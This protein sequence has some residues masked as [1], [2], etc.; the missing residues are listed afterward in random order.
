MNKLIPRAITPKITQLCSIFPVVTIT[1]PRQSGK[2]TLC[3]EAFPQFSYFN[4]ECA[5]TRKIIERGVQTWLET[6]SANGKGII[7]D[8]AQRIPELFSAV[9]IV[10]DEN[11]ERKFILSG[12]NNFLLMEKITQSLAGRAA[13]LKL[14]PF[15]LAELGKERTAGSLETLVLRGGFPRV[16]NALATVD[17]GETVAPETLLADIFGNYNDTYVERDVRQIEE[18]RNLSAFRNFMKL[19][20][21]SVG[22]EFNAQSF[23]TAL[24]VSVPTIQSWLSILEASYII[25]RL[26]PFFKNIKKR[27]SKRSKIYFCD[28][29]LACWL[30][31]IENEKQL[32]THP[33]RGRLF[34]NL[35]VLEFFKRRY[36]AGENAS[37]LYFYRDSSQREVDIVEERAS[38]FYAYEIKTASEIHD[39]FFRTLDY[40]RKILGDEVAS[41]KVI[42]DGHAELTIPENGIINFRNL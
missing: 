31:D 35:V 28:T 37:R 9:Q 23:A 13:I 12:S 15:S 26:P 8:E 29:G 39:D 1:G 16:W 4:L 10:S 7:I 14:L 32:T 38:K 3:R 27:L 24:S 33:A 19:C 22:C 6:A 42:Y 18:I 30:L 36:A 40:F 21:G 5:D 25:F 34:E 11:P 20:A 17:D 41:T 2:T